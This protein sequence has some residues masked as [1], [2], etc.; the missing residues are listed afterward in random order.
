MEVTE[1]RPGILLLSPPFL[2][3]PNFRRTVVLLIEHSEEGSF[4]LILNLPVELE[5]GAIEGLLEGA[6]HLL[7]LGGPVEQDVLHVLHRLGA[8]IDGSME[9]APDVYWG[10]D[11][12]ALA[13][14]IATGEA[15]RE[16]IRLFLGYA[17]WSAGQLQEEVDA[18][19]W[20][21]AEVHPSFVFDAEPDTLWREVLRHMGGNY[22]LM[23]NFPEDPRLN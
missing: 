9:I 23:A 1:P 16:D 11:F 6:E 13:D 17:G 8:D 22:A 20:I 19:G 10:G 15:T 2:D 12:N 14:V 3:D 21:M 4:G 5:P 18:G 7:A